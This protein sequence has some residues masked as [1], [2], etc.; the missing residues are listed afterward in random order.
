MSFKPYPANHYTHAGI[1]AAV[2][3]RRGGVLARDV[4]SA[5]LGVAAQVSHQN[6][7]IN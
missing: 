3:L 1:D 2:T 5:D 6:H 7:L 4:E